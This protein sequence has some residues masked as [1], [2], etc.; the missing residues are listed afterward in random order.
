MKKVAIV[1]LVVLLMLA[2]VGITVGC[3]NQQLADFQELERFVNES[4][5]RLDD[6]VDNLPDMSDPNVDVVELF[7][8]LEALEDQ[9]A[10]YFDRFEAEFDALDLSDDEEMLYEELLERRITELFER[11][12]YPTS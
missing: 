4:F 8:K 12:G 10:E 2:T 11:L 5:D 7:D 9:I 6:F 1:I 3:G